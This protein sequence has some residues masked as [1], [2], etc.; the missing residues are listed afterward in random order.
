[1]IEKYEGENRDFLKL[2]APMPYSL[3]LNHKHLPE[4]IKQCGLKNSPLFLPVV[5]DFYKGM[6]VT[7]PVYNKLLLKKL[8]SVEIHEFFSDY[9]KNKNF[10]N[11]MP[12]MGEGCLDGTFLD[13]TGANDTNK[14]EIFVFGNDEQTLLISRLDN[15]GKGSSGAAVQC[16]NIMLGLPEETGLI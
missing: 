2:K 1:M 12:F 3:S 5:G 15:L 14:L 7:I 4:I 9:Y 6:L 13:P 10:V 8:S 11:V 16:M